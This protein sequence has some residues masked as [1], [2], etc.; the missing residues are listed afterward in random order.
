[1]NHAE[2]DFIEDLFSNY[3][4]VKV[5]V[6]KLTQIKKHGERR[7]YYTEMLIANYPLLDNL[8]PGKTQKVKG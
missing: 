7:E 2:N 8:K 1:M 5:R 6:V 4:I 3:C